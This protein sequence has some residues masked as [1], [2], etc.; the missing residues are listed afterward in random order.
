MINGKPSL[1]ISENITKT[2][3]PGKKTIYRF[4]DENG[5]F[6]A[7][8]IALEKEKS[9]DV[10]YHPFEPEKSLNI[11]G[12][13]REEITKKVM[14]KGKITADIKSPEMISQFAQSRLANLPGEHKRFMNP[15]T[16][17]VGISKRLL[18]LRDKLAGTDK[19]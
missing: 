9:V 10:L 2:T 7:D 3:L 6:A 14:E 5:M 1:K 13:N 19:R 4:R 18:E 17:K 12:Y 16:Y 15:H 8:G 11:S